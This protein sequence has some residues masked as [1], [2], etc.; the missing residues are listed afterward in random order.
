[1]TD[2]PISLG[3]LRCCARLTFVT[4]MTAEEAMSNK[5]GSSLAWIY[6]SLRAREPAVSN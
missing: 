5:Q 1:V 2:V 6:I 4:C 3:V